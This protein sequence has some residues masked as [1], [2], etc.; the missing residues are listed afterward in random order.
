M[1][2]GAVYRAAPAT[3]GLLITGLKSE[4][5]RKEKKDLKKKKKKKFSL[6]KTPLG[7]VKSNLNEF[8]TRQKST[9]SRLFKQVGIPLLEINHA[10]RGYT[11]ELGKNI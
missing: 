2:Q 10:K 6:S 4:C 5:M 8:E 11:W 7:K 9:I 1:N 3:P